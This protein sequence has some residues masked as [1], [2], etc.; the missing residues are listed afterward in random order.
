MKALIGIMQDN[1]NESLPAVWMMR[2]GEAEPPT[3]PPTPP[4]R[5]DLQR[6]IDQGGDLVVIEPGRYHGGVVLDEPK[7]VDFSGVEILGAT[8]H[9]AVIAKGGPHTIRNLRYHTSHRSAIWCQDTPVV[10][11]IGC[12]FS[13]QQNG[14][15][16]SN[17]GG[18]LRVYDTVIRGGS[19][20]WGRVHCIY[21]GEIDYFE[22]RNLQSL[23]HRS[24]GHLLKSRAPQNLVKDS[25]FD[26][27][28]TRHS[29]IMDFPCGGDIRI[30]NCT[31]RQSI[32][33]DNND[34]ISIA[35]EQCQVE[36]STLTLHNTYW[37][38]N[39][40]NPRFLTTHQTVEI[41][42]EGDN[43]FVNVP[44]PDCEEGPP[45]DPPVEPPVD[46]PVDPPVEPPVDPPVE[47]P[48][49]C[50]E[51]VED[52]TQKTVDQERRLTE[53]EEAYQELKDTWQNLP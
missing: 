42:C 10:T 40:S 24:A 53:L 45:V 34:L 43:E 27:L 37:E 32:N 19:G 7:D 11:V 22:C 4:A 48:Q 1:K 51:Q 41:I 16:T 17:N 21:A 14:I 47:P 9:G 36:F 3:E 25:T 35:V 6:Q 23:G 20:E 31:M 39:K 5:D 28:D 49:D 52:L 29:R 38:A 46:P 30:E 50:C 8:G 2:V 18:E 13:N 15:I 33:S 26:G 12:D 44:P